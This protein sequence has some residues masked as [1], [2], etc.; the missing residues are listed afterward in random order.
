MGSPVDLPLPATLA[1]TH[2][3]YDIVHNEASSP[4]F[5]DIF[6]DGESLVHKLQSLYQ[7]PLTLR[8]YMDSHYDQLDAVADIEDDA[9]SRL[10]SL[11]RIYCLM[12]LMTP[13]E[14]F[15]PFHAYQVL[16]RFPSPLMDA[17]YERMKNDKTLI[18][19]HGDRPIP[20]TKWA[21]S[22][23]FIKDMG[24]ELPID[25]FNQAKEYQKFLATQNEKFKFMP[26]HASSG[27]MACLL[28]ALSNHQVSINTLNKRHAK[29]M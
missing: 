27:M 23:K 1:Q 22:A 26:H 28:N 16:S 18:S 8:R 2:A 4:Y 5:E 20:G 6:H 19:A 10:C 11:I 24:G 12:T 3:M 25:L 17:V 29:L 7:A 14:V 21:L 13:A 15:D 9:D